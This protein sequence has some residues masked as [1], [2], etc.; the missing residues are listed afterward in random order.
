[1]ATVEG[2]RAVWR[3]MVTVEVKEFSEDIVMVV[4]EKNAKKMKHIIGKVNM[5]VSALAV[6]GGCEG[7]FPI[8]DEKTGCAV[9][10]LYL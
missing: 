2:E 9:G 7:H 4:Q 10:N 6:P 5:K 8:R 1:M 3:K